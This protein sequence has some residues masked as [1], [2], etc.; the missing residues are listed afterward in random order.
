[1]RKWGH[2]C[3]LAICAMCIVGVA[4][5]IRPQALFGGRDTPT[6][7]RQD[8]RRQATK[9]S[10]PATT[11]WASGA[12][13]DWRGKVVLSELNAT[14]Y[15]F[16]MT[17]LENA[18]R[19]QGPYSTI[20]HQSLEF[21][22]FLEDADVT[23][24]RRAQ[25]LEER[26]P[27]GDGTL[28]R[29]KAEYIEAVTS[30]SWWQLKEGGCTVRFASGRVSRG[31]LRLK[32]PLQTFNRPYQRYNTQ[33]LT[34]ECVVHVRQYLCNDTSSIRVD[35]LTL[36]WPLARERAVFTD[37]QLP[38]VT[39]R[40]PDD[41]INTVAMCLPPLSKD[42]PFRRLVEYVAYHSSLGVT[43][44]HFFSRYPATSERIRALFEQ[45]PH[46]RLGSYTVTEASFCEHDAP[47]LFE[48]YWYYEHLLW[49][50][51][52]S[53]RMASNATWA[54]NLEMDEYLVQPAAGEFDKPGG[55]PQIGDFYGELARSTGKEIFVLRG[56]HVACDG[57]EQF[58]T[59]CSYLRNLTGRAEA[60]PLR[61]KG[62]YRPQT[63]EYV[64]F[65]VVHPE[66][67]RHVV[68]EMPA[69]IHYLD[70]SMQRS[71]R[72]GLANSKQ[73]V[74]TLTSYTSH[75]AVVNAIVGR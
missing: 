24:S 71:T 51:F 44:F 20:L 60:Q 64:E 29:M 35:E 31:H 14:L 26:F 61:P 28:D 50:N 69:L 56:P 21:Q 34:F 13:L 27:V 62:L 12:D 8:R 54:T 45:A 15:A 75:H 9:S 66:S 72:E 48:R 16:G 17:V 1:M 7:S 63:F 41:A 39:V 43:G 10:S 33:V 73:R 40:K 53:R 68:A 37:L 5:I 30:S 3:L 22:G 25:T 70:G 23:E 32:H 67:K 18:T 57:S 19:V 55:K 42:F 65:H 47:A 2:L 46:R 38:C 11:A 58:L 4:S 36:D 59:Q 6:N 74:E 52:C 49:L